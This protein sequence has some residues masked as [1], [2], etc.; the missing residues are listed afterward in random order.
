[1]D[2]IRTWA[3]ANLLPVIAALVGGVARIVFDA[4]GTWQSWLRGVFLA[5]FAGWLAY[6]SLLAA[7]YGSDWAVITASVVA[8]CADD[9][10]RALVR[11]ARDPATALALL[12]GRPP[13]A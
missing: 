3:L 2:D 8:F 12:R 5:G 9:V 13:K 10:L 7:G 4:H 1:M 11:L 6:R